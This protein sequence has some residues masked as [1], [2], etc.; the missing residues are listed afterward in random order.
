MPLGKDHREEIRF[1][2]PCK[3]KA[4]ARECSEQR[5][6]PGLNAQ[7]HLSLLPRPSNSFRQESVASK[8]QDACLS[9]TESQSGIDGLVKIDLPTRTPDP[10]RVLVEVAACSLNFRDLAIALGTYRC[11]PSCMS[12]RF[13]TALAGSRNRVMPVWLP[14]GSTCKRSPANRIQTGRIFVRVSQHA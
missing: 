3:C 10:R 11:R 8:E 7:F 4:Q 2:C 6:L 5:Q 13:R 1:V 14:P 12:C 9:V